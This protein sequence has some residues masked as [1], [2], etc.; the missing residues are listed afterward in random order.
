MSVRINT[1]DYW[2]SLEQL[3]GSKEFTKFLDSEF[4]VVADEGQESPVSRRNF[5]SLMGASFA[6]AGLT[7]CRRPVEKIVPHVT[8]PEEL[9]PGVPVEYNTTMPNGLYA[10]G[11]TVRTYDGRPIKIEGNPLHPSTQGSSNS[12]VQAEI[13]NI[14]D[15]DRSKVVLQNG[16]ER[17]WD[18]FV[19]AWR[20]L[21]K[22]YSTNKGEG[23]AILSH[24]FSS[25]TQKRLAQDLNR[26]FANSTWT[27]YEPVTDENSYKG[28][29]AATGRDLIPIYHFDK[30]KTI[31]S[32]DSDFLLLEKDSTRQTRAFASGRKITSPED[33]MN[34]LYVVESALTVTGAAADHRIA[35]HSSETGAFVGSLALKL[36]SLGIAVKGISDLDVNISEKFND[37]WLSAVA[38]DL[39]AHSGASIVVAGQSQSIA[40]HALVASINSALGNIGSTV[41]YRFLDGDFVPDG[42]DLAKLKYDIDN[43][44]VS[45]LIILGCNPVY[46]APFDFNLDKIE[47]TIHFGLHVDETGKSARWH[48]PQAHFLESWGDAKSIQ[49]M[50]SVI[51]PM[52]EPLYTD[53]KSTTE[54]LNLVATGEDSRGYDIVRE[55]WQATLSRRD[56]DQEW[57]KV[58][59]DGIH[60]TAARM[61]KPAIQT[62]GVATALSYYPLVEASSNA[63]KFDV[64]LKASAQTYDGRNANNG[65]L[66]ENPDPITKLVW[67]NAALLSPQTA[68]NL[69]VKNC[70]VLNINSGSEY[71]KLPVWIVPGQAD[72]V[73]IVELGFGRKSAGRIG[74]GVGVN[75]YKMREQAN[76]FILKNVK[77][78][79]TGEVFNIVSTQD[80]GSMEGRPLVREADR[81]E[82]IAHPEF[83]QEAV[84]HPPLKSLWKEHKYDKGYQWGMS[85]DLNSCIGCGACT[86]ACQSENNIAIVGKEQV[87]N[88]REMH[89]I[90]VDRYFNGDIENP[91]VVHQPVACQ[92]CEMAPCEGVCPVAATV[93]DSEG[94]NVMV[95]NRC[96]GTRYC[97]NNCPYKVRRFNFYNHVKDY[98][99]TMKMAQNPNVTVRSRG[100]MEKCTYCIQ[101]INDAKRKA[102]DEGRVIKDGEFKVACEQTCPAQAITFGNVLDPKSK[103]A[104][105]KDSNRSYDMLG[106]L[107]LKPRTS[108]GAKLRNPNPDLI[109]RSES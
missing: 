20:E 2:K 21:Y 3:D 54:F 109:D 13:L 59:H 18:D 79:K 29:K 9:I 72:N 28:I 27:A 50:N 94:L 66:L 49:G 69:D 87:G 95:Y 42:A 52:I 106:E 34:R 101:R 22:K 45:T 6:L 76:S 41:E 105:I 99:E 81:E 56:F 32:I 85:I 12:F 47:N 51:Q 103:I 89:W 61:F 39:I 93:H 58:L 16:A 10:Y 24:P 68:Q 4:P 33:E 92:H 102:K 19:V 78:E 74:N 82:Y 67:D 96:V 62:S 25:P 48:A 86:T 107:N 55:T 73:I 70:D 65:W 37:K 1:K 11:V 14:Y 77:I 38:S 43:G 108:Y 63:E 36:A 7:G 35:M 31:L 44:N 53:A 91:E 83:A 75:V 15:P 60:E 23:L 98:P 97:A 46:D 5:L 90:R 64:V 26:R 17:T 71:V 80:H 88:G 30:A 40:V 57:R 8:P 104:K 100:V 84:E